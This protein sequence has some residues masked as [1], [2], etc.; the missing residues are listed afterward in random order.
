MFPSKKFF[1]NCYSL[2]TT[3]FV[4]ID[5]IINFFEKIHENYIMPAYYGKLP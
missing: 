1:P 2:W 3:K 4:S 5:L